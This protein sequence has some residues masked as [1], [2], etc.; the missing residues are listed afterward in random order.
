MRPIN[1]DCSMQSRIIRTH[2]T[3]MGGGPGS[4]QKRT[5]TQTFD[6]TRYCSARANA[7]GPYCIM[8]CLQVSWKSPVLSHICMYQTIEEHNHGT[9]GK[10]H[11]HHTMDGNQ[12]VDEQSAFICP[13]ATRKMSYGIETCTDSALL[14]GQL[15]CLNLAAK[16]N[17]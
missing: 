15:R 4:G 5:K 7:I 6:G 3:L 11:P 10:I 8:Y 13:K 17:V 9:H 12:Q 14:R 2:H 1:H 16:D